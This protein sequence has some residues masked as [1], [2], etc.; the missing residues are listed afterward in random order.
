[1]HHANGVRTDQITTA[2]KHRHGLRGQYFCWAKSCLGCRPAKPS[3]PNTFG[4]DMFFFWKRTPSN[5]SAVVSNAH[6][7]RYLSLFIEEAL[8]N[9]TNAKRGTFLQVIQWWPEWCLK[10]E[11]HHTNSKENA[12]LRLTT[13]GARWC[14]K[15]EAHCLY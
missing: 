15:I 10:I 1:M 7:S 5:I 12:T 3:N 8:A 11:A 4:T 13:V 14:L 9:C 2:C 6:P